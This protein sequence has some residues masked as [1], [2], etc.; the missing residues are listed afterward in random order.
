GQINFTNARNS[1]TCEQVTGD[2]NTYSLF[3]FMFGGPDTGRSNFIPDTLTIPGPGSYVVQYVTGQV[4]LGSVQ[5]DCTAV[6]DDNGALVD[7]F[8]LLETTTI[9]ERCDGTLDGS[10]N[11]FL[12][13]VDPITLAGQFNVLPGNDT[14]GADVVLINFAD[15]YGP[16]Y[17]PIAAFAKIFVSLFDENEVDQSCG[18]KEVCF[19]RLGIDDNIVRSE[20]FTPPTT[21]PPP[22]TTAPPT[23]APPPPTTGPP[24]SPP[25]T[26]NGGGGGSSSCAI[27]GNPVQLGTALANVLIPLVPVAFAFG[28][29]AVRRRKK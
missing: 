12:D 9:V 29:R 23:T 28:V 14:A 4:P 21:A 15:S 20:E 19:V 10:F 13:V 11:A 3:P 24:T 8:E 22:P 7:Q 17:R 25:P 18:D 2:A 5:A 1:G 6:E 27:A 26:T 16:P